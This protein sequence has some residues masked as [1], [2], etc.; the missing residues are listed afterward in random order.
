MKK[1]ALLVFLLIVFAV[2]GG[3]LYVETKYLGIGLPW[4]DRV[5][6]A[7]M[8][9]LPAPT[10]QLTEASQGPLYFS[11]KSPYD[12]SQLLLEFE[13]LPSHSGK[14]ELFLPEAA[15]VQSPVP[16]III[17]HGS[18]GI[19]PEREYGYAKIFNA[20][21]IAAFV[22]DYYGPRGSADEDHYIRKVLSATESDILVDTYSA[23]KLLSTHPAIDANRIGVTGYSYGGMVTRYALD[24]RVKAIVAPDT[25]PLA[26]H[27]DF[28]GPC[29]QTLG[30]EKTTGGAYLA[31]F[32][33]QDNSVDPKACASIQQILRANGAAVESHIL[34][35][36]G[37]AWDIAA[38]R[39]MADNPYV[40]FT[41][42]PKTGHPLV[43]GKAVSKAEPNAARGRRAFIRTAVQID[44]PHCVGEGYVVGRDPDA[45][46]KAKAIM[47]KFLT[48]HGFAN[49]K[50]V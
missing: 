41:Y 32:G 45:D 44:T 50:E 48:R 33:D 15:S 21:G 13:N 34:K 31:I 49:N 14:G 10:A 3:I 22:L 2:G 7:A 26:L 5:D 6:L 40:R 36:A 1:A 42:D 16:V 35:G 18:G 47:I 9:E 25:P 12:F 8:P 4:N 27:M 23:Q 46:A 11:T 29:H 19:K 39:T 43:D 17:L 30:S 20:M 28:Y 38:A 37:H 24:P